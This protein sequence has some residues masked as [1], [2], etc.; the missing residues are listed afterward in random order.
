MSNGNGVAATLSDAAESVKEK[1]SEIGEAVASTASATKTAATLA[2]VITSLACASL[3]RPPV[4]PITP[5]PALQ[6]QRAGRSVPCSGS[7]GF[8]TGLPIGTLGMNGWREF[9]PS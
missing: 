5:N 6:P 3:P 8:A 1:A 2:V 4:T 9:G 7:S